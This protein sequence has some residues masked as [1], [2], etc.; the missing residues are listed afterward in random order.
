MHHN[1]ILIMNIFT[2]NRN[3]ISQ[4]VLGSSLGEII[5]NMLYCTVLRVHIIFF[6][7]CASSKSVYR[8]CSN[9]GTVK[10][11]KRN[12]TNLNIALTYGAFW[13]KAWMFWVYMDYLSVT[14]VDL[15]SMEC[16]MGLR[17]TQYLKDESSR[18][19]FEIKNV[20]WPRQ[21]IFFQPLPRHS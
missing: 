5:S 6:S 2:V 4:A 17:D 21:Q 18:S 15:L 14:S 8:N 10:P 1:Y 9:R 7:F 20:V 19:V 13:P 16:A 11:K 12:V 3:R